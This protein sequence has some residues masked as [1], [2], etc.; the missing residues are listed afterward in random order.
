MAVP[1]PFPV[2]LWSLRLAAVPL[3]G[4]TPLSDED[5]FAWA[6]WCATYTLFAREAAVQLMAEA[7]GGLL[8]WRPPR[9]FHAFA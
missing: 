2:R 3:D 4:S 9:L 6:A 5:L 7:E 8:W 1:T